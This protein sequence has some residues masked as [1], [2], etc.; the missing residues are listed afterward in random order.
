MAS[1]E[2]RKAEAAG[3]FSRA[4]DGYPGLEHFRHFG[5]RLV[6]LAR[7]RPGER[8]LDVATGRGACLLPA[9]GR[10]GPAGLAVGVDLA[11]GMVAGTAADVRAGRLAQ[12]ALARMD[13]ERLGLAGGAFDAVLCGF[14]LSFLPDRD[15]ALREMRRVLRP[16]GRACLSVWGDDDPGW[17]WL[18][19]LVDRLLARR[20][21][22]GHATVRPDDLQAALRRAGFAAAE[23][24]DEVR[25]FTFPTPAAWLA[26]CWWHGSRAWMER[27]DA[28]ALAAFEA[29]SRR[30]LRAM[31]TAAGIPLTARARMVRASGLDKT[32]HLV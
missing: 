28:G 2:R 25:L 27:M 12:A 6:E 20:P 10:V 13:A 17:S 9:A 29:E 24:R 22:A 21:A 18:P 11:E 23:W 32:R 8:V 1:P 30:H 3:V 14:G 15:A 5:R 26:T 4:A 16:G 7:L 31:A 19:P